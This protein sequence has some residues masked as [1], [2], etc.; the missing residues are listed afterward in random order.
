MQVEHPA[1]LPPEPLQAVA[2]MT[3]TTLQDPADSLA[4]Q[5][6]PGDD[7]LLTPAEVARVFRVNP[8]TVTRWARSGKLRAI[9]TLG[10]HRRFRAADIRTF[11]ES[12]DDGHSTPDAEAG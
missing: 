2:P 12:A 6:L 7:V 8:K 9:R 5:V 1:E 4:A 3:A 10:G 11:L